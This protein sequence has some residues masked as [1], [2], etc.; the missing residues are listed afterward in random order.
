[1]SDLR[2]EIERQ[3]ELLTEE[4]IRVKMFLN[5][6][7]FPCTTAPYVIAK[8]YRDELKKHIALLRMNL[9]D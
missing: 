7:N 1:M 2:K 3:L 9:E 6:N 8:N 4:Q 5:S